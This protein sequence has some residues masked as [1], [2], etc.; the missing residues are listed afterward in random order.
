MTAHSRHLANRLNLYFHRPTTPP[1]STTQ[2]AN[3]SVSPSVQPFLHRLRQNVVILCY[4][5][6]PSPLK[7]PFPVGYLGL[8]LIHDSLGPSNSK[9]TIQ[10]ASRSV[11]PFLPAALRATQ[12]AGIH[13]KADFEGF[14]PTGAIRC[15]DWG[16]ILAWRRGSGPLLHAKFH[17][18]WCN[19]KGIGHQK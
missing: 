1:V 9:P 4:R 8:H 13:S 6:S 10:T 16:E 19:D 14:R 2:T 12:S 18:N 11:Q 3:R 7:L 15:T 17:P 5:P